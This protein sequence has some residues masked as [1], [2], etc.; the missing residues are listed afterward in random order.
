MTL[1][2]TKF[3]KDRFQTVCVDYVGGGGAGVFDGL[4]SRN[5]WTDGNE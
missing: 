3:H 4:L 2:Y 1:K 5:E